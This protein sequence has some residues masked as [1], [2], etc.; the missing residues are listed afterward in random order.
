MKGRSWHFPI[1]CYF[2]PMPRQRRI[3]IPGLV[4]H[5][6]FRGV[7]RSDIF[8]DD[9]DREG[10]ISRLNPLLAETE[11]R[12]YAWALLNNHVHLLLKPTHQPLAPL[13]RR[14]LTGYAVSFNLR[15]N[16]YGHLFQ[17]SYKSLVCDVENYLLELVR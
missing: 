5:V 17:N 13:M 3:D 11:T 7:A 9:D 14:L 12:C 2:L 16:R 1:Y 6:I 8:L 10:F 15:H 4:Q